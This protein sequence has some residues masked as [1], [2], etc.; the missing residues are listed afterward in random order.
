MG[1]VLDFVTECVHYSK[2]FFS[3]ALT[4]ELN[5]LN[6][7]HIKKVAL[8]WQQQCLSLKSGVYHS[9]T[10]ILY[11]MIQQVRRHKIILGPTQLVPLEPELV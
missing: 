8:I 3:F 11:E 5:V 1:S 9:P 7:N 10:H 2:V 6:L 4:F